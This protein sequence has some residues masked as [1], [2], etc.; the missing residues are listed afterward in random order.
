VLQGH[1]VQAEER[2]AEGVPV[3]LV[4][5]GRGDQVAVAAIAMNHPGGLGRHPRQSLA[6]AQVRQ[7]SRRVGRQRDGGAD[8]AQ[9]GGLLQNVSGD[10]PAA[11]QQRQGEPTP[12]LMITTG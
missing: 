11:Q 3:P 5:S 9:L 12:P 4:T 6:Q 2:R 1:P 7:H 8:L 10:A